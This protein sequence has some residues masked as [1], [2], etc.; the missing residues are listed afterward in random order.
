MTFETFFSLSP[1]NPH[2]YTYNAAQ[3]NAPFVS[4][5]I[6]AF[7]GFISHYTLNLNDM[8]AK[9]SIAIGCDPVDP[10]DETFSNIVTDFYRRSTLSFYIKPYNVS[11]ENQLLLY[12]SLSTP[13]NTGA[14]K[15]AQIFVNGD[16]DP[17][18]VEEI[19]GLENVAILLDVEGNQIPITIYVRLASTNW[20]SYMNFTGLESVLL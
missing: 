12:F 1:K 14:P 9:D 4:A 20:Y 7:G 13:P 15:F 18:V 6:N 10:A 5:S 16:P 11:A 19:N 8:Y 2:V 3:P 17:V